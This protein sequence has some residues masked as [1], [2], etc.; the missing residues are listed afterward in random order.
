[1][2]IEGGVK[3]TVEI[4]GWLKSYF[5]ENSMSAVSASPLPEAIGE[6]ID[7]IFRRVISTVPQGGMMV[8]INGSLANNLIEKGYRLQD[9]DRLCLI[10]IVAGG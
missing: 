1:V 7:Q 2:T 6:V 5:A 3:V 9:G 4:S 8:T 10:P